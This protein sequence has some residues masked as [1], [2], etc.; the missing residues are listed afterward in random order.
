MSTQKFSPSLLAHH[1]DETGN[2]VISRN[3][4]TLFR[5]ELRRLLGRLRTK[6]IDGTI[7][8]TGLSVS[9]S[10]DKVVDHSSDADFWL[11][12][13]PEFTAID[14]VDVQVLACLDIGGTASAT[15]GS[16]F[17]V[18]VTNVSAATTFTLSWTRTGMPG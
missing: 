10:V 18:R 6:V 8:I 13:Y 11:A 15:T 2:D 3:G 9:A 17:V 1:Y 7:E 4:H 14:G 16:Q 12:Q 5:D